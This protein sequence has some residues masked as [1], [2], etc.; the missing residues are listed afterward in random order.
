MFIDTP[1]RGTIV[2]IASG[3]RMRTAPTTKAAVLI[4]SLGPTDVVEVDVVREYTQTNIPEYVTIGDMWGHVVRV[5]GV[6]KDGWTAIKYHRVSPPDISRQNYII[7]DDDD[8]NPPT[9]P[10]IIGATLI[11][12]LSNGQDGEPIELVVK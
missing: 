11:P 7:L 8:E 3:T 4:M 6:A 1:V 5:N 12:K 9:I 2:P 10:T